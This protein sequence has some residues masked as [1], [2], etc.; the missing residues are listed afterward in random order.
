MKINDFA[1]MAVSGAFFVAIRQLFA[2]LSSAAAGMYPF[3]LGTQTIGSMVRPA[4]FCG[5]VAYKPS[6]RRLDNRGVYP[7]ESLELKQMFVCE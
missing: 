5:V 4:S 2:V 3:A 7:G 6:F 1:H